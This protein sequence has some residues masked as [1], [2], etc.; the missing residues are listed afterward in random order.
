MTESTVE[1]IS[2]ECR[3]FASACG[4]NEPGDGAFRVVELS[5]HDSEGLERNLRA[6]LRNAAAEIDRLTA[7]RDAARAENGRLREANER[8]TSAAMELAAYASYAEM[9][10]E[11]GHNR[12]QIRKW[13]DTV[14]EINREQDRAALQPTPASWGAAGV[15]MTITEPEGSHE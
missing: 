14:F 8:M 7:E 10:G 11:I 1:R 2:D 13:C 3:G 6:V 5:G 15:Q 12:L 9:V 4:A